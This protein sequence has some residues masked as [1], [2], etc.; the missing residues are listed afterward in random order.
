MSSQCCPAASRTHEYVLYTAHWDGLG[1]ATAARRPHDSTARSTTPRAS[2]GCLALAQSFVPHQARG[3]ALDRVSGDH[4][5]RG[6]GLLGIDATTSRTRSYPLRR[7]AAVID[8]GQLAARA[9]LTRDLAIY[10]P[11]NSDI[12]ESVRA[13]A[14]LQGREITA[15]RMPERACTFVRTATVCH[16]GVP[17]LLAQAGLDNAARGPA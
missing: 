10:A 1:H 12:E 4:R 2:Q 11:G 16:D 5:G 7:T 14:L 9:D 8:H 3:R 6:P 13:A 15:T 17:A